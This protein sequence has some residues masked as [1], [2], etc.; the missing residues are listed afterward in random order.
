PSGAFSTSLASC[1][2]I[3]VGGVP[4][5]SIGA[6]Q[7]VP[8]R[9]VRADFAIAAIYQEFAFLSGH[10]VA[11]RMSPRIQTKSDRSSGRSDWRYLLASSDLTAIDTARIRAFSC[12]ATKRSS[13]GSGGMRV[14]T[15]IAFVVC[16]AAVSAW[17]EIAEAQTQQPQP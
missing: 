4:G 3:Q 12:V 14:R 7:I 15:T 2:L 1:G 8:V 17:M 10:Y 13:L 6:V 5:S 9:F 16:F 11:D